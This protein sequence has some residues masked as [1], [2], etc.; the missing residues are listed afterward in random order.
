[1]ISVS[2]LFVLQFTLCLS[3]RVPIEWN[4][5]SEVQKNNFKDQNESDIKTFK[6]HFVHQKAIPKEY[7][8]Y[9]AQKP[10][11][12][13]DIAAF[14]G[15]KSPE[16]Y[17]KTYP[18]RPFTGVKKPELGK[19]NIFDNNNHMFEAYRGFVKGN[20]Q[21][22]Y[23]TPAS[24]NFN[25]FHPYKSEEPALK[26]IYQDPVLDKIRN[27]LKD[28]KD[29][30]KKYENDA[31]EPNI[32]KNEYLEKPEQTDQKIFPHRSLP[33]HFEIHRPQRRPVYYMPPAVNN[34]REKILNHKIR[35]PWNQNYAKVTPMHYRPVKNHLQRL[36]QQHALKYD[37]ENNEYPQIELP[38]AYE[39]KPDGYDI[40]EKGK[41]RFTKL[42]HIIDESINDAINENHPSN[43]QN[44]ELQSTN[45][46]SENNEDNYEFVPVKN[47]AQVRKTETV[48]HLPRDAA[49]R[50]AET[51]DEF[52][53]APRLREAIKSTKAQT[54]YSE[55]GY[56]DSAY[57][58]AG[59]QKHASDH[60]GHGGYLKEKELSKGKYKIP[61]FSGN[62][63]DG[64]GL[65]YH[66]N[67]LHG[68]KW[69]NVANDDEEQNDEEDYSEDENEYII[70]SNKYEDAPV[71]K[72]I[73]E[74]VSVDDVSEA[75]SQHDLNKREAIFKV[76][77]VNLSSNNFNDNEVRKVSS[78]I[79]PNKA[80]DLS[81]KFPYYYKSSINKDSPLRYAENFKNIPRK[82]N[83]GTEF[84]D[85]R[86]Q[87]E[88]PEV[89]ENV[90]PLPKKLKKNRH[91]DEN[92][93]GD[94]ENV[95]QNL[96]QNND[97]KQRLKGLGDKIDCFKIKY[98]GDN[99]LDNPFF[100]EELIS[101]PEPVTV[102]ASEIFKL[103]GQPK[104]QLSK[105]SQININLLPKLI[106][107]T[108]LNK[109]DNISPYK[110]RNH[111]FNE[112]FKI[113]TT[114]SP[115][116]EAEDYKQLIISRKRRATPFIYEP[117]KIIRDSQIQDSK[118]TT[119]TGNIS[120]LIKQLQSSR[121]I[122]RVTVNSKKD[123]PVK[124]NTASLTYK[125]I[126]RKDREKV[127]EKL[128]IENSNSTFINVNEDSRQSEPRFE[129][130]PANHKARYMPVENKKSMSLEAYTNH[131][132]NNTGRDKI[133]E[134][135]ETSATKKQANDKFHSRPIFDITKYLPQSFELQK[136][137]ASNRV[138]TIKDIPEH[139]T[140]PEK[141]EISMSSDSQESDEDAENYDEYDEEDVLLMTTTTT[142]PTIRK[143][144][145]IITTTIKP[146]SEN[147]KDYINKQSPKLELVT[148]FWNPTRNIYDTVRKPKQENIATPIG[149]ELEDDDDI[150]IPKYREKKTKSS[151]KT[152]VTDSKSYGQGIDDMKKDEV[153]ELIGIKHDMEEY[154]PHYEKEEEKDKQIQKN[155]KISKDKSSSYEK[156]VNNENENDQHD[157]N[158]SRDADY[159][160]YEAEDD[161]E[162][163]NEDDLD[164]EDEND[165]DITN[166]NGSSERETIVTTEPTKR[167]LVKTTI[168]PE[169]TT[170]VR[171]KKLD[172]KPII[173]KK[174]IEIHKELP[175][176]KSSQNTTQFKQDIKEIEIIKKFPARKAQITPQKYAEVLQLYKDENLAKE[177]NNLFDVEVFNSDL[178]IK[179]GP[180]HGGNY[181][182]IEPPKS[183]DSSKNESS[184]KNVQLLKDSE[185]SQ[186]DTTNRS[187]IKANK[188]EKR[189]LGEN[190]KP[191]TTTQRS[192]R[193]RGQR[194]KLLQHSNQSKPVLVNNMHGGNL[195]LNKEQL[196][197]IQE[198]KN[199]KEI[200]LSEEHDDNDSESATENMHG[201]NF[202][203]YNN[204]RNG[205]PMHGGNYRSAKIT[206]YDD[207]N[208]HNNE[209]QK[210]DH[211]KNIRRNSAAL[212][213]SFARAVPVLTTTPAYILDPS[214]RMY[215]YVDS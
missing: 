97:E 140:V 188:S 145:R 78:K 134:N 73:N 51:Y 13:T 30:L 112:V 113:N 195:N 4:D 25:I 142:K 153:D 80:N 133:N 21:L 157:E 10:H 178:D 135:L 35:H 146:E 114:I 177:V 83:G 6:S 59:E 90:D 200:E 128:E 120:P 190:T 91:P 169:V 54:V 132:T 186:S 147:N 111:N 53:N 56:E 19:H 193:S 16:K 212:L 203:T 161:D 84:Y 14:H 93:D 192:R 72:S 162:E 139:K 26:A 8:E 167:T 197:E 209:N 24:S 172:L 196:N 199:E 156:E 49:F 141:K 103:L 115:Q 175:S 194:Y 107:E 42:R 202:K 36:R 71:K 89:E 181:R 149:R 164:D 152:I 57:D 70:K 144:I 207:K 50:D 65:T 38:Q 110:L 28:S 7:F 215:Y 211:F 64:K 206:Q 100:D 44:L 45:N 12:A 74:N 138:K 85:S 201:G 183:H 75:G 5:N 87:F 122:D 182:S 189:S 48:K 29:R 136:T 102:P 94:D 95:E 34:H 104:K 130:R 158:D 81:S 62:Y 31:G 96:N 63:E 82:S 121:V 79:Q 213:D 166:N 151:K 61:S 3:I 180:R 92:E 124:R 23:V 155:S 143:I 170:E 126:D 106:N 11:F 66:D 210:D 37:D 108:L 176:E 179:K 208:K 123:S 17:Y 163:E 173:S 40:Y 55:E 77:E 198:K 32:E 27:D 68:E 86:T 205:N 129:Q 1:M 118:K 9:T 174:K 88:C 187:D 58:H 43:H 171:R 204:F 214:K 160:S 76:P 2:I 18:I 105:E 15:V 137:E 165:D 46:E 159:D 98:F 99:P 109:T 101:N 191:K 20:E 150:M 116:N 154:M 168:A 131:K 148:R 117:Y 125:N 119:T 184:L 52:Q 185:S 33:V 127:L 41:E 69:K 47:Y 60:E 67:V 22:S 39:E